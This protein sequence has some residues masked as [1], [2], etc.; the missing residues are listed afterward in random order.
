M[1]L[2]RAFGSLYVVVVVVV[3][4]V[5]CD[6]AHTHFCNAIQSVELDC[7]CYRMNVVVWKIRWMLS[8]NVVDV[9]D[10]VDYRKIMSEKSLV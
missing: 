1:L 8:M 9:R 3:V 7:C 10:V 5:G 4:V 6:V 2:Y